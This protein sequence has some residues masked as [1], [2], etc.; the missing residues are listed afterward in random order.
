MPIDAKVRI[1]Y[2]PA[3]MNN[4]VRGSLQLGPC[5][6]SIEESRSLY[7]ALAAIART[8]DVAIESLHT[9]TLLGNIKLSD[10]V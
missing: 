9:G 10:M 7:G 4:G 1:T 2:I 3:V 8:L 6:T 5:V